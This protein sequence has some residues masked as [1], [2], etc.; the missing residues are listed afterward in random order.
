MTYQLVQSKL[1]QIQLNK[2]LIES[3]KVKHF[4][5][6]TSL[7]FK[8]TYALPSD[9]EKKGTETYRLFFKR[10]HT[11]ERTN[12]IIIKASDLLLATGKMFEDEDKNNVSSSHEEVL[13]RPDILKLIAALLPTN[14]IAIFIDY[15]DH[16]FAA[17]VN[18]LL[19]D[20][21]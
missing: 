16:S 21:L 20:Q 19:M 2:E 1:D 8:N 17:W 4:A 6:M 5:K 10:R 7:A 13:I 18:S 12:L 15:T 3:D 9:G 11:V 14:Q